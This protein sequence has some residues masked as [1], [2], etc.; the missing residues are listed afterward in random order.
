MGGLGVGAEPFQPR[1]HSA[2]QPGWPCPVLEDMAEPLRDSLLGSLLGGMTV[3]FWNSL[4]KSCSQKLLLEGCFEVD[5][6]LVV[7]DFLLL[8]LDFLILLVLFFLE[9]LLLFDRVAGAAG[10]IWMRKSCS[11]PGSSSS[12]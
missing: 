8:L 11:G 10:F 9:C 7:G 3:C 12:K 2:P 6:F 1:S 4:A 5:A